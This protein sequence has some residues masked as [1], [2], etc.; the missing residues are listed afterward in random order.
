MRRHVEERERR[1]KIRGNA[2]NVVRTIAR[3]TSPGIGGHVR[4]EREREESG[5]RCGPVG[6]RGRKSRGLVC[7][8]PSGADVR[9]MG[10]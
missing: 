5:E 4:R 9:T 6:Q 2:R 1:E 7:T 10:R 3:T 8:E